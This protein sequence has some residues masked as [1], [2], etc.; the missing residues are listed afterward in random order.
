MLKVSGKSLGSALKIGLKY[1]YWLRMEKR[2][3]SEDRKAIV[4][5]ERY[6]QCQQRDF[7]D[8][9]LVAVS[10]VLF[11]VHLRIMSK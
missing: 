4:T 10:T 8:S 6:P 9:A 1:V 5:E 11:P 3:H 7:E 2:L